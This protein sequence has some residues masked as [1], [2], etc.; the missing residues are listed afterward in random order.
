MFR[1]FRVWGLGFRVEGSRV[2]FHQCSVGLL[3]MIN[4]ES[5][6]PGLY[7]NLLRLLN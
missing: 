3:L 4:R 7:S 2:P 6:L 5:K 1:R